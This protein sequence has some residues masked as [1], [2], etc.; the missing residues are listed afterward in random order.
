MSDDRKELL[1]EVARIIF[2]ILAALLGWWLGM[3]T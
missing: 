1:I 2:I 3:N